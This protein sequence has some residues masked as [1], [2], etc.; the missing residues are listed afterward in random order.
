IALISESS[1]LNIQVTS[2]SKLGKQTL[3]LRTS[4]ND[5]FPGAG[6]VRR[7][8][9][10]TGSVIKPQ[11]GEWD[12]YRY[13]QKHQSITL[14]RFEDYSKLPA[15]PPVDMVYILDPLIATGGTARAALQ[16]ILDWGIPADKIKM[17]CV[18]ASKQGV[19]TI[20]EEFPSVEGIINPGR[21]DA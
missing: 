3:A 13:F 2:V 7:V 1:R 14:V 11:I 16:M 8:G 21:G 5:S 10:F 4:E 15:T 9:R 20:H 18:L 19:Q 17:L 12:D 6:S